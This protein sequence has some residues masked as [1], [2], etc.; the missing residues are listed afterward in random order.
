MAKIE[1]YTVRGKTT[2]FTEYDSVDEIATIIETNGQFHDGTVEYIGHDTDCTAISFK[3]YQD[4]EFKV[5]RL[6]FTGNV[7]LTLNL[8]LL[9]RC[10][11]EIVLTVD[12][13]VDVSFEGTGIIVKADKVKYQIQ[14]LVSG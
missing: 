5:H 9:I 6:I 4:P 2:R 13:R 10:I 12:D 1:E 8:D 7:E 11:Y 14:E 3:H